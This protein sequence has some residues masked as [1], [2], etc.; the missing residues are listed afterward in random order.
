[1]VEIDRDIFKLAEAVM[2]FAAIGGVLAWQWWQVRPSQRGAGGA[3]LSQDGDSQA[4][5]DPPPLPWW[6]RR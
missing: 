6:A 1:V 2:I 5:G 4:G 3:C